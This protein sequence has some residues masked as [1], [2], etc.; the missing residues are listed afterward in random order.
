MAKKHPTPEEQILADEAAADA[1]AAQAKTEVHPE[2]LRHFLRM[3]E[4][5]NGGG[6]TREELDAARVARDA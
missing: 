1:V 2:A 3:Q 6:C 4:R 5:F